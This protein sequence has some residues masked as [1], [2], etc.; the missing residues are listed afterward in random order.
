[1]T[2]QDPAPEVSQTMAQNLQ[3]TTTDVH[4]KCCVIS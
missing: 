2:M 4:K 1:M 3:E